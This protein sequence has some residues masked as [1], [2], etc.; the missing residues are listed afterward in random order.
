M[1]VKSFITHKLKE[2]YFDCQDR[3]AVNC[4][5]K[6]VAVSDGMSQ[7]IFPDY[8]ADIL[9]SFYVNNGH[10]TEEDRIPLCNQWILRVNKYI[11]NEKSL[12]KNPWRLQNSISAKSGAGATICGVS[13]KNESDWQ[14][15]VLGDSCIIEIEKSNDKYIVNNIFS[16]EDKAFDSNPD[17]YDSFP[18][19]KGCGV[20]KDFYGSIGENRYLLLVSDPFSEFLYKHKNDCD[21][22]LMQLMSIS[23]HS[24]YCAFVDS[25]REKGL[26]ND[27][28]TICIISWDGLSEMVADP[29]EN[30][31]LSCLVKEETEA[32]E[33]ALV[34]PSVQGKEDHAESQAE[35]SSVEDEISEEVSKESITTTS[36]NICSID[37]VSRETFAYAQRMKSKSHRK[38]RNVYTP[39]ELKK[40]INFC[41]DCFKSMC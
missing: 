13:F 30:D 25:W 20:I 6:R 1:K 11:E 2:H 8:W 29:S 38:E 31:E 19:R 7:S 17:Y 27:D 22:F 9:S 21:Y 34:E 12:G 5:L 28:S 41:V 36:K 15:H 39:K 3:Y 24:D 37:D 4:E 18:E 14:G 16:S 23:T 35:P 10:C 33:E 40:I 26:H 32:Q